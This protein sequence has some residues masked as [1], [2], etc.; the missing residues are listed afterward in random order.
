MLRS[1]PSMRTLIAAA[2]LMSACTSNSDGNLPFAVADSATMV[3]TDRRL[4]NIVFSNFAATCSV[5]D[6]REHPGSQM[7]HFLLTDLDADSPPSR[8]G[9]YSIYTLV[10]FPT[11]GLAG[12]C[13]LLSIDATCS[14]RGPHRG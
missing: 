5:A 3:R 6:E 14:V 10:S 1:G 13:G 11:T 12:R 8:P 4:A 2:V 7:F 9:T